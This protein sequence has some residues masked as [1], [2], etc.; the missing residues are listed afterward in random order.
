MEAF[1]DESPYQGLTQYCDEEGQEWRVEEK[2][3]NKYHF[4]KFDGGHYIHY[5]QFRTNRK[6]IKGIHEAFLK[7]MDEWDEENE[8]HCEE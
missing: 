8:G 3:C 6:S 7:A 1:K 4:Y 2:G 5:G